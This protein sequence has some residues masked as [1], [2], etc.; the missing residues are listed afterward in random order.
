MLQKALRMMNAT[1]ANAK[2]LE[3]KEGITSPE[4]ACVSYTRDQTAQ[5]GSRR[6][7]TNKNLTQEK[8][9]VERKKRH[10]YYNETMNL[11]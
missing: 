3:A 9:R 5:S 10:G 6:E 7:V 4:V 2:I 8:G 11:P 1:K